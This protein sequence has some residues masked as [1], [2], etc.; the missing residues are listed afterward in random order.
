MIL[1]TKDGKLITLDYNDKTKA[2][3]VKETKV[4]MGEVG[5]GSSANVEYVT[6]GDKNFLSKMEF[7]PRQGRVA[8]AGRQF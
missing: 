5:L 6:K 7:R 2:Q 1:V 3:E 8:A 4:K